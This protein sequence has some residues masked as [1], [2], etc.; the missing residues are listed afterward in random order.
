[1]EGVTLPADTALLMRIERNGL[2]ERLKRRESAAWADLY[3]RHI[4]EIFGYV[5]HLVGRDS[6]VAEDVVQETW[7]NALRSMA[8]FDAATDQVRAWL[9]AIARS[10]VALHF[11]RQ[12]VVAVAT[13]GEAIAKPVATANEPIDELQRLELVDVVKASLLELP[14]LHRELLLAKYVD[15]QSVSELASLYGKTDKAIEGLLARARAE[16]RSV[17][18]W[19]FPTQE[20]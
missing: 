18:A 10:Q 5:F 4:R 12:R 2:V 17:L 11:R 14:E 8:R 19:Y 16:L 13:G 7:V 6:A 15:R 1:M 20:R 9:F 3:D